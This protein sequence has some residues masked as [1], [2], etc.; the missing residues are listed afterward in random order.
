MQADQQ[1]HIIPLGPV[2]CSIIFGL[3]EMIRWSIDVESLLNIL[4]TA[5]DEADGKCGYASASAITSALETKCGVQ[6][7]NLILNCN[8]G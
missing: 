3:K 7:D 5:P 8:T 4:L 6:H 2:A 1:V